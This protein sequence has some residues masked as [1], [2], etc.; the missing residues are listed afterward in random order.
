MDILQVFKTQR[1]KNPPFLSV[2]IIVIY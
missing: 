2:Y 1:Q